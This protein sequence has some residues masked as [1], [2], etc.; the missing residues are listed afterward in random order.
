MAEAITGWRMHVG[1]ISPTPV[2]PRIIREFYEVVPD[3]VDMTTVSLTIQQLDDA[4]L[5]AALKGI[6]LA[7]K[8]LSNFDVDIIYLLGVPPIV[9]KGPGFGKVLE[10]RMS[11]ASGLPSIT[12]ITG[13]MDAMRD[14]S[15]RTLA[16]ATPFEPIVNERIRQ[17]LR[18][19][20]IDVLHMNGLG[21]RKNVEIRRLP[22]PVEYT[23]ARKTYSESP[24]KPDGL[25]IPC[26]GWGSIHHV[27]LLERD[28]DT[29][30][31]TWMNAFIWSSMRRY[32]VKHPIKGFGKLLASV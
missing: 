4:N 19:E 12:D 31:V 32:G 27:D 17:Y 30:V 20:G 28:L 15:L 13:V 1:V 5:D 10:E 8:Q 26:G 18:A 6:E 9:L 3:G 16:M 23:F 25:Y 24:Q 21:I 14:R 7:C 29:T 22:I 2:A 11:Q